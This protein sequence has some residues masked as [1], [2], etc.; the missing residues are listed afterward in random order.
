MAHKRN[1]KRNIS[2]Y[3]VT[4]ASYDGS[5]ITLQL[6]NNTTGRSVA[7]LAAGNASGIHA[8]VIS[9]S[10]DAVSE[11]ASV[12][13]GAARAFRYMARI[14]NGTNSVALASL[15][16]CNGIVSDTATIDIPDTL[17]TMRK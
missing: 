1:N 2:R 3:S 5:V 16:T 17:P 4:G 7:Y 14:A 13:Y 8:P 10:V 12:I 15:F 11:Q 6:R 9:G